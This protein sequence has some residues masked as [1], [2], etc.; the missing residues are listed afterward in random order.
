MP[1]QVRFSAVPSGGALSDGMIERPAEA[2]GVR[3]DEAR[4][5]TDLT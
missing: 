4:R 1:G 2:L 3:V 5:M